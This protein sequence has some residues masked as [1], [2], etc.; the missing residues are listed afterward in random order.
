MYPQ[1]EISNSHCSTLQYS[2]AFCSQDLNPSS[3]A[4]SEDKASFRGLQESE[5]E[6]E[7]FKF[8]YNV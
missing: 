6:K 1:T 8:H 4:W 7:L 3:F 2:K 5:R